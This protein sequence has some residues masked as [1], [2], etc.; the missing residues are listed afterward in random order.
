[1]QCCHTELQLRLYLQQ[2]SDPK[3][4]VAKGSGKISVPFYGEGLLTVDGAGNFSNT[5]TFSENTVPYVTRTASNTGTYTVNPDC[6]GSTTSAPGSSG[7]NTAFVIVN[8]GAEILATD[9]SAPDMLNF[10]AKKQ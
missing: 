10:D 1:M 4:G 3:P 2:I 9:T 5:F 7:D 8:G 6:T